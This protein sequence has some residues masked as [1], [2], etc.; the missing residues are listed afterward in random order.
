MYY[1]G[2]L[3]GIHEPSHYTNVLI[4]MLVLY[5]VLYCLLYLNY[6][7]CLSAYWTEHKVFIFVHRGHQFHQQHLQDLQDCSLPP[8]I[9]YKCTKA[10]KRSTF[11]IEIIRYTSEPETPI[12]NPPSS[13][14]HSSSFLVYFPS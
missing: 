3:T 13:C 4:I 8:C 2:N 1:K 11:P 10:Q 9:S 6:L 14:T 7:M 12:P 5:M